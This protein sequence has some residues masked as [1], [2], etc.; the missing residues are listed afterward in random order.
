MRALVIVYLGL[1]ACAASPPPQSGAATPLATPADLFE[2][3]RG[4]ARRGELLKAEQ[5]MSL[6]VRAG[7][8]ASRA[9]PSLVRVCLRASRLRAAL[10]HAQPV[11]ATH[12]RSQGLRYLV[13]TL[14]LGLGQRA[15]AR[16]H[17]GVLARAE[18]PHAGARILLT[19]LEGDDAGR[20]LRTSTNPAIAINPAINPAINSA[21]QHPEDAR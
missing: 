14:H 12:P 15:L 11:L 6:A 17:L 5:Y 16:H 10:L 21:T 20:P 13:A 3:G 19:R 1:S 8:P 4:L 2:R 7:Y 9:L 18:Q